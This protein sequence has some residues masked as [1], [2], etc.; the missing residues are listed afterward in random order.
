MQARAQIERLEEE[1]ARLMAELREA[2]EGARQLRARNLQLLQEQKREQDELK[3]LRRAVDEARAR[4][5]AEIAD[6]EAQVNDLA[7]FLRTQ[8]RFG[9]ELAQGELVVQQGEERGA[10][11]RRRRGRN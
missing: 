4:C 8:E 9:D 1:H 5:Q 10:R 11:G 7:F 6:L 2:E 3:G